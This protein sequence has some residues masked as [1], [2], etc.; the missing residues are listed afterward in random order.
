VPF[1]HNNKDKVAWFIDTK[2]GHDPSLAPH[3]WHLMTLKS[4][5]VTI[6]FHDVIEA[7]AYNHRKALAQ[8]ARKPIEHSVTALRNV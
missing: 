8:E 5:D 4:I 7:N 3:L 6:R 2:S 1:D